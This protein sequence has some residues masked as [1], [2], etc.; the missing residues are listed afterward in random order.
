[1]KISHLLVRTFVV[2]IVSAVLSCQERKTIPPNTLPCP[3]AVVSKTP[4]QIL[5]GNSWK[6]EDLRYVQNNT[7]RYYKRGIE[8]NTANYDGEYTE[9]F[10]DNTGVNH[11]WDLTNT[12]L[13]WSFTN[14]E[15]TTIKYTLKY[16]TPL[17]VTWDNMIFSEK[18][19]RYTESYTKEGTNFLVAGIRTPR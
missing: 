16:A 6:V 14:T 15:K 12:P 9:F 13:T 5:I 2:L 11:G 8:Y 3:D 17:T 4:E 18:S 10:S 7:F 19:I 1:M